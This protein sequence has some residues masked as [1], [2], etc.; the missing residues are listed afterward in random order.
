MIV[1]KA[2]EN[3]PGERY[4]SMRE[5]VIDIRRLLRQK[6][7]QPAR[8]LRHQPLV[9][10]RYCSLLLLPRQLAGA[11]LMAA[12]P[13]LRSGDRAVS[14]PLDNALFTRFTN[15]EGT[16]R[17]GVISP[18]GRFVAFR[19]DRDGPMDVWVGQ[20]G[21]GRFVNLTKG[22]DDEFSTD[23]PSVGFSHDGSEIWLSG[24][25][26]RRL[27]LMPLM[28][29]APHPF[30]AD[31]AVTVAWSPDGSRVVYHLQDDGDSMYVA[32]RTGAN[33]RQIFSKPGAHNH[34]PI[35]S[36][37]GRWIYFASGTPATKEMDVW[38]IVAD[39]GTPER[40]TQ[41]N[42]DV[43]YRHAD[44]CADGPVRRAR[45]GRIGTVVV[46]GRRRAQ[47]AAPRQLRC[48]EIRVGG[49]DAGRATA[50]GHRGEPERQ[51]VDGA[52]PRRSCRRRI[53]REG[54]SAAHGRFKRAAVPR[55]RPVLFVVARCR[56]RRVALRE[57]SN[58]L[59]SGRAAMARCSRP[60]LF[61]PMAA[62]SR[63]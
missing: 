17:S 5:M 40:L 39:G 50:R 57:W 25:A 23:T 18:D 26:G 15:F 38:R 59:K 19:S 61:R 6:L 1:E 46:V 13:W 11:A 63:L 2:L 53:R 56:R 34:F 49:G 12:A 48:R 47:V 31:A 54:A 41:Q 10:G 22:I 27:R 29:G 44:R 37:D 45:S 4:Q 55:L 20:V 33:P 16:E 35:W 28:G 52:D 7:P 43:A 21:T 60:R 9:R 58:P 8:R 32:D 36:L 3:D 42:S 62:R 51:P 24:G 30:L 14:N